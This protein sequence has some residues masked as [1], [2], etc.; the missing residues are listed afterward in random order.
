MAEISVLLPVYNGAAYLDETLASLRQQDFSAFEVLCIDDCSTDDSRAVIQRH[1]DADDRITYMNTGQNLGSAA[2]AVNF[3]APHATGRWFVYSSQDDLFSPDWLSQLHARAVETGADAVLPDVVFYH[4]DGAEDRRITGYR[5]DRTAILS[6]REAFVASLDWTIPGNA[7][8]PMR[9]LKTNGFDDFNA[10]ADEYTVRRFFLA[11][12][13]IAF[14]EGVFFYRQDNAA[15]ITKGPSAARLDAADAS[16]RLWQLICDNDFGPDVHGP[17]ALRTLR[18]AIRAQAI[19]F[20][21]PH[22]ASEMP[23]LTEVWRAM[24]C[25][26]AFQT[27]LAASGSS[28][29]KRSVYQRA[30]RSH[31]WFLRLARLSALMARR[32]S[33]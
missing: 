32:K 33:R 8:W 15:A 12:D 6:G 23:R 19:V 17:F 30:V 22:L 1:A 10:F 4:R 5:G 29:F 18:A 27:S 24:H 31:A 20:N 28:A 26:E 7:L 2:K 9:L 14:C 21:A 16:L 13:S 11:C 25:S 3:A